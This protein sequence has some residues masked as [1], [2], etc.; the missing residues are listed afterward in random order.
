[1]W[2]KQPTSGPTIEF[3]RDTIELIFTIKIA[4]EDS[5]EQI[6]NWGPMWTLTP[7]YLLFLLNETARFFQNGTVSCTVHVNKKD[8][9]GAILNGT[10]GLLLPLDMRGR[11]RRRFFHQLFSPSFSKKHK[12]DT[13]H[14]PTCITSDPWPT[15]GRWKKEGM[16]PSGYFWGGCIVVALPLSP[17]FFL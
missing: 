13:D 2:K 10:V 6:T 16:C 17:L 9:N 15:K 3:G 5:I 12:K 4:T 8:P 7:F 11:G 14:N 1:M